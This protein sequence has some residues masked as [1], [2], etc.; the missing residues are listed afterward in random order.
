MFINEKSQKTRM[1]IQS[2][3]EDFLRECET[4]LRLEKKIIERLN[5]ANLRGEHHAE[6]AYNACEEL[7][8]AF[9]DV[10]PEHIN[11]LKRGGFGSVEF[12]ISKLKEGIGSQKSFYKRQ[13][14]QSRE[15]A[16]YA[17][18]MLEGY[19]FCNE[20]LGRIEASLLKMEKILLALKTI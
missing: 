7:R 11:L 8:K 14:E 4:I 19:T 12:N 17:R 3:K 16:E 20:H 15:V 6:E 13:I 2:Q 5:E 10:K 18:K 9:G 1:S